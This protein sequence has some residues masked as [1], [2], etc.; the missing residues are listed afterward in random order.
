MQQ[1]KLNTYMQDQFITKKINDNEFEL[2]TVSDNKF[3]LSKVRVDQDIRIVEITR[4]EFLNW[5]TDLC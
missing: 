3:Y 5:V 1:I 4:D 2:V